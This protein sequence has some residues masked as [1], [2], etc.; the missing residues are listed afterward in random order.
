[1]FWIKKLAQKGFSKKNQADWIRGIQI[2][3]KNPPLEFEGMN[4][5]FIEVIEYG[6]QTATRILVTKNEYPQLRK[7]DPTIIGGPLY[8]DK[9]NEKCYFLKDIKCH[10]GEIKE[11][12]NA[13][14]IMKHF[15][16]SGDWMERCYYRNLQLSFAHCDF[17]RDT[18]NVLKC[19]SEA[20]WPTGYVS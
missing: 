19:C 6:K 3:K 4:L 9:E 10:D 15:E 5:Y 2:I 18:D 17:P 12:G 7:Y 14:E 1:M 20:S 13:L 16:A 8:Y 11:N